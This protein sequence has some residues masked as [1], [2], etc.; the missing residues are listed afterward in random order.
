VSIGH[1]ESSGSL[2]IDSK[3]ISAAKTF[4]SQFQIDD[5][6]SVIKSQ[7]KQFWDSATFDVVSNLGKALN[8]SNLKLDFRIG[9]Y[10]SYVQIHELVRHELLYY[11]HREAI[12]L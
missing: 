6:S 4:L 1:L 5:F 9:S 2:Q 7:G 3:I 12:L 10:S 11:Y 8:N